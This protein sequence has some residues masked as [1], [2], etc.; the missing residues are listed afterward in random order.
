MNLRNLL[1]LLASAMFLMIGADKF[2]HYLEPPCSLM[3]EIN[4][5]VWKVFGVLQLLTGILI[6][7]PNWR[8]R[9]SLFFA[10]FMLTFTVIHLLKGTSD[11]GGSAFMAVLLGLITWNPK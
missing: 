7:L 2:L 5:L 10:S 8:K 4:P 1:V 6:W 11:V 3:D 9:L